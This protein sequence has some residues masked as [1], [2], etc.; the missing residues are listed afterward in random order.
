M[1]PF[2]TYHHYLVHSNFHGECTACPHHHPELQ[3]QICLL[4]FA[5]VMTFLWMR[6]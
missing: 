1:H 2:Q 6:K 4:A 5:G 3:T